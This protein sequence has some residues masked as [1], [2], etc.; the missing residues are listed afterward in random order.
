[1]GSHGVVF[2][3]IYQAIKE[4][5]VAT[6]IKRTKAKKQIKNKSWNYS[7]PGSE[8]TALKVP[9]CITLTLQTLFTKYVPWSTK[10]FFI[11]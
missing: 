1:M 6:Y 8:R 5:D 2:T 3:S 4:F 10:S 7:N 11:R 9:P